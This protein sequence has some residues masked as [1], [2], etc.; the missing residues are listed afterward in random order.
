MTEKAANIVKEFQTLSDEE[1]MVLHT[2][3]TSII[4]ETEE[5]HELDSE[6]KQEIERRTEEVLSGK[7]PGVDAFSVLGEVRAKYAT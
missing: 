5:K 6:W 4:L 7:E 3:L 1:K 2:R